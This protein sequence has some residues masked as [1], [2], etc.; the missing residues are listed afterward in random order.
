MGVNL[1]EIQV[2]GE[3]DHAVVVWPAGAAM[4]T[5][6]DEIVLLQ[7]ACERREIEVV[8]ILHE[9]EAEPRGHELHVHSSSDQ[10]RYLDG[11]L[12]FEPFII[13]WS[14]EDTFERPLKQY[15]DAFL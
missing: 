14:K 9:A 5:T 3:C 13:T 15:A 8:L 12:T 10:S 6:A 11:I 4:A 7:E 1:L 2:A